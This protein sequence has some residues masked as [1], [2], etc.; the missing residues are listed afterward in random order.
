LVSVPRI[1]RSLIRVLPL[2]AALCLASQL[3]AQAVAGVG[4]DAIPLPKG[5]YRFLLSGLWNDYSSVYPAGGGDRTK[6]LTPY[7]TSSAGTALF[8]Q[9]T[10]AESGIRTLSGNNAF[11]LSL[12]TL[13][14]AGE[15]RQSIAPLAIDYGVTRR[16][17]VRLLVPYVESRDATQLLLNRVGTGANVGVNPAFVTTS[18]A[19]ARALNGA[20]VAQIDAARTALSDEI[21]RCSVAAATNCDAI[22]ANPGAAQNLLTQ[23]LATRTAV[24]N[25]YGDAT[26]GGAPVVPVTG[27]TV[28]AGVVQ[29]ID[30]LR[31]GFAAYG[32]GTIAN[33]LAPAPATTVM[34]PAGITRIATDSSF[35]LRYTNVGNTR[36]AGIGDVD[37]TAT[38]LLFDS[39]NADQ[40]QRLLRTTRGIRSSLT[41]GWRFG[42]AGADRTDDPFDVPIGEGANALLLRSTT[43]FVWSRTAWVS[44]TLR[45]V[46]PLSDNV[47][48]AL[49]FRGPSDA[50]VPYTVA[51]AARSLGTRFDL[52]VAPRMSVGDFFGVSGA[53]L[54]R[55]W[56]ADQYDAGNDESSVPGMSVLDVPSRTLRAAAIGVSFSTLA[57]YAR[58]RSRFPAEI[59]YTHTEPLGASGGVTP[60]LS[61]ERLELRVYTGFPRR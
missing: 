41:G 25:V 20:V 40:A 55:H 6:L 60:A 21:T 51:S 57:S 29:T 10:A 12:G 49:P 44:A 36:R 38:V 4:D 5:G 48:V 45:A 43:D 33:G 50:F 17:S 56:G 28:Q 3:P 22:R 7:V 23:A 54:L 42:M 9:L 14:A 35:G 34:G 26:R 8:P 11:S 13:D 58:G 30:G 53:L 15:V 24:V 18:S 27:S 37:L 1:Q 32:I 47:A 16:V 31:T 19:Q 2:L 46:K 61:S 52:E 39:F 59:I